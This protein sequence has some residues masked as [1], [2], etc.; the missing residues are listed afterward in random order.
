M[1]LRIGE[2]EGQAIV[3][4]RDTGAGI[5]PEVLPTLF[6]DHA[7]STTPGGTGL[8]T[9]I[10]ARVAAIHGGRVEVESKVGEGTRV[11]LILPMQRDDGSTADQWS[12]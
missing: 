1:R 10:V 4:V 5:A 6:T 3:E 9:R 7:I 12:I 8:G 11:R 2:R